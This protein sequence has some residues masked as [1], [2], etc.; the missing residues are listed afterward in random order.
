[1]ETTIRRTPCDRGE[2]AATRAQKCKNI[3]GLEGLRAGALNWRCYKPVC[4]STCLQ[5]ALP[6]GGSYGQHLWPPSG[7]YLASANAKYGRS[8]LPGGKLTTLDFPIMVG[9]ALF[10][11]RDT[12]MS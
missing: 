2:E 6:R 1:M 11:H 4:D 3:I 12:N 10:P 9:A 8:R 5:P 7:F